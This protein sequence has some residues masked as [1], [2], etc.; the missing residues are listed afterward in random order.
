MSRRKDFLW[1][2]LTYLAGASAAGI[3]ARFIGNVGFFAF[4]ATIPI[5]AI[6]YFTSWTYMKNVEA[7]RFS[8]DFSYIPGRGLSRG[9][10]RALYRQRRFF[11]VQRDDSNHR[12]CLLHLLDLHE[13]CR[14]AKI[15]CGLLLHTWPGPQPRESSRALS[16][17]SVFLRSARRFQSSQ[18]FTSPL[19]LT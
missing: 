12:N 2:S 10:H 3:I 15:F 16:A 19:G 13:E 8:V 14:G 6:V 17:T 9:N 11:C 7:Q 1:T 18:L 4:S 5:I